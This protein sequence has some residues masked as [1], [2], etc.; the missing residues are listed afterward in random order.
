VAT[1][2]LGARRSD[3]RQNSSRCR[4]DS[5]SHRRESDTV[6]LCKV[7]ALVRQLR[8]TV[9]P[10]VPVPFN[11]EGAIDTPAMSLYAR[12][13]AVQRIGAVAVWA[14]TGRGLR[15]TSSQ[16][17]LVLSVWREAL[18]STPVICGVGVQPGEPL[19][20]SPGARTDR[21]VDCSVAMAELARDGGAAA[22][23]VYPPTP[24]RDLPDA[25]RRCVEVHRAITQVGLPVIAF[26][27]YE[28]AGGVSYQLDTVETLLGLDGVVGVKIAT[29]DSVMTFQDVA[30]AVLQRTDR[31]LF[32][33]EDRFLGYT[34]M[35][36]AHAALI[37]MAAA[38]TD[39]CVE[40]VD[41][42]FRQDL[43]RFVECSKALDQFAAA[44]FLA[45]LEGYVQRMLWALE[46][47]G[48]IPL[49]ATDPFAPRLTAAERHRVEQAVRALR[50]Q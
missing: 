4:S 10:A 16:L 43:P 12:W 18:G 7:K 44:T 41:A 29:L 26:Y 22:V 11:R 36:G 25:D 21:V 2:R 31:L 33:G 23:L 6:S 19:P 32:T 27:L 14:H 47:D 28:A 40:L 30:A 8:H 5:S 20:G 17:A 15:L 50:S 24:L 38:C 39:R 13:M 37:G 48:V 49:G 35:C 34:L 3:V 46:V 45:P 42:W 1:S 9:I